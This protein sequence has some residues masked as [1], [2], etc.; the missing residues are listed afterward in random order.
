MEI[1][2]YSHAKNKAATRP[3]TRGMFTYYHCL[4][5]RNTR[6]KLT[7]NNSRNVSTSELLYGGSVGFHLSRLEYAL[8]RKINVHSSNNLSPVIFWLWSQMSP[9]GSTP[10]AGGAA[11]VSEL[12]G[13]SISYPRTWVSQTSVRAIRSTFLCGHLK[14]SHTRNLV[15]TNRY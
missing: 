13:S 2:Q 7:S 8:Q 15:N 1:Q 5:V 11:E 9:C 4:R 12:T 3:K 14:N 6:C 10:H